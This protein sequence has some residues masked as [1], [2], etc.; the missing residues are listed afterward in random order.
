MVIKIEG[1]V[2]AGGMTIICPVCGGEIC[3]INNTV[4]SPLDIL[5]AFDGHEHKIN[6]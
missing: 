6:G 5:D 4:I 3:T 1:E 2:W